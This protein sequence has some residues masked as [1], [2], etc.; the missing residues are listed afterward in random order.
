MKEGE[1]LAEGLRLE[2]NTVKSENRASIM[3]SVETLLK[4]YAGHGA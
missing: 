4:E 2:V 3:K 1:L